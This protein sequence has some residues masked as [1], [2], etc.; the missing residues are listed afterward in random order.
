MARRP[1]TNPLEDFVSLVA[2]LPWWGCVGAAL[3]SYLVLHAMA[4]PVVLTGIQPSQ[5]APVM[6]HAMLQGLATLGQYL[7]PILCLAAA[8]VSVAQRHQ[9]SSLL[10]GVAQSRASDALDGMSWHEFELL[11]GEAF[12]LQGY[13]VAER[14][15]AGPDGGIDLVLRK[16]REKFLVQ[17]KQWKAFKV[18]VMI[19]RELYGVMAASGA[20]GGFV[21]TSGMFTEEATLF[22]SGRN[23]TLIDGPKLFGLIQQ[24]RAARGGPATDTPVRPMAPWTAGEPTTPAP[25]TTGPVELGMVC[26]VCSS[27]MV[28][29]RAKRGANA[30][31]AFWG[32]TGYPACRGTR[33]IEIP[34]AD[35]MPSQGGSTPASSEVQTTLQ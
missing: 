21:V 22:A 15:G 4:K 11:V 9:R 34:T 13:A 1:K 35:S 28:R 17:C 16:G 20:T 27:T 18:G 7:V 32:C 10:D 12:R 3:L 24:A 2:F 31:K 26:L 30:G 14:G 6:T 33:P 8:A 5:M 25:L 19:V 29:R 23:V